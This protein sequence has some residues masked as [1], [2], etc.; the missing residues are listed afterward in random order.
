MLHAAVLLVLIAALATGCA[1]T[2]MTAGGVAPQVANQHAADVAY[3]QMMMPHVVQGVELTEMVP[4]RAADPSLVQLVQSM[5]YTDVEEQGQLAGQLHLWQAPVPGEDGV[6]LATMPGMADAATLDRLR[7]MSGPRFDRAWL[8]VMIA[9]HQG[10]VDMSHD[11]LDTGAD[12]AL[13][14]VAETQVQVSSEQI[15][16]MRTLQTRA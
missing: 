16:Q 10:G 9:H 7:G 4:G 11:Y 5:N 13:A 3:A 2:A 1:N 12:Q 8:A 6:P 14:T 15:G